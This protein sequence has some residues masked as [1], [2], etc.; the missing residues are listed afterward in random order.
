MPGFRNLAHCFRGLAKVLDQNV[1]SGDAFTIVVLKMLCND[2]SLW[3]YDVGAGIG[4]SIECGARSDCLI[5]DVERAYDLRLRI[6]E[7]RK[8]NVLPV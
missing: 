2:S 6:G 4:N 8:R 3:V 1:R 7:Q 5:Q